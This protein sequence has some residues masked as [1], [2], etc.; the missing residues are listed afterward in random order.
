MTVICIYPLPQFFHLFYQQRQKYIYLLPRFLRT[1]N[2]KG[3]KYKILFQTFVG[4][5][6]VRHD[7]NWPARIRTA[8]LTVRLETIRRQVKVNTPGSLTNSRSKRSRASQASVSVGCDIISGSTLSR[9]PYLCHFI[10]FAVSSDRYNHLSI[11]VID[12]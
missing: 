9:L 12:M 8:G 3:K 4:R 11:G 1:Q 10:C 5:W 6:I 2:D 7:K